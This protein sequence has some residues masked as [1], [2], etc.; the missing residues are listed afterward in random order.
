MS[1]VRVT[2]LA[3]GMLVA[4]APA[5]PE[6]AEAAWT[7]ARLVSATSEQGLAASS[8]GR[9]SASGRYLVFRTSA[10][11]LVADSDRGPD[12]YRRAGLVRKDLS[13]GGLALVAAGN[14][15]EKA[16]EQAVPGGTGAEQPSLSSD[17]RYVAFTT[18]EALVPTDLNG[19]TDVY[20]RDMN[21]PAGPAAYELA[22]AR[23][24]GVTPA[25][26]AAGS[27]GAE[28]SPAGNSLTA[29][30]R[31]VA[32]RVR[33]PN[34]LPA[35]GALSPQDDAQVFLRRLDSQST[36]LVNVRRDPTTGL[37]TAQ[38]AGGAARAPVLSGDGSTLAWLDNRPRDQARFVG[39]EPDTLPDLLWRRVADGPQA[40]SRRIA[41]V[42]DPDHPGCPAGGGV[43]PDDGPSSS[44]CDGFFGAQAGGRTVEPGTGPLALSADGYTAAFVTLRPPRSV[45]SNVR[46]LTPDLMV[47]DMRPGV[48]RKA[49]TRE[50]TRQDP[51]QGASGPQ[52]QGVNSADLSADANRVAFTTTTTRFQLS[53]P[54]LVGFASPVAS[55][56]VPELY[57]ADLPSDRLELVTR[58][59]DNT[60]PSSS[61]DALKLRSDGDSVAFDSQANNLV[62]GDGNEVQDVFVADRVA[63]TTRPAVQVL[64]PTPPP[65]PLRPLARL[66]ATARNSRS[67]HLVVTAVV[68]APGGVI[69]GV[70][71]RGRQV[72]KA[73]KRAARAGRVKLLVKPS[74]RYRRLLRRRKTLAVRVT[75]RWRPQVGSGMRSLRRSFETQLKRPPRRKRRA[76]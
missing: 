51:P 7:N 9:P 49:G 50:L 43:R 48:T 6:V 45:P 74:S 12:R 64:P 68:P 16:S 24:G 57:V 3:A 33:G 19:K 5:F 60:K 31:S 37:A 28:L 25:S 54:T 73:S 53:K 46:G 39:G 14:L 42:G 59:F 17:G 65:E 35:G 67:G 71:R 41:P 8:Q 4:A 23:D 10:R 44:P 2:L 18:T 36:T 26:Y 15:H 76:G 58:A 22:S 34:D 70:S 38:G 66:R 72:G 63:E 55:P 56:N 11:N 62:R 52:Y 29:D 32:F 21:L 61:T 27:L 40:A 69:A 30:G 13:S 20:V 75:V 47:T 1:R